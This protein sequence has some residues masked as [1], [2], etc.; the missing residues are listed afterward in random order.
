MITLHFGGLFSGKGKQQGCNGTRICTEPSRYRN[1][2]AVTEVYSVCKC[3]VHSVNMAN[4]NA[5]FVVQNIKLAEFPPDRLA[6]GSA[7]MCAVAASATCVWIDGQR[8]ESELH[9]EQQQEI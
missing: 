3:G 2:G 5:C 6:L 1:F 8:T 9:G 4:V 7:C